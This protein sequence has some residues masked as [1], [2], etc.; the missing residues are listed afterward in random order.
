METPKSSKSEVYRK[1]REANTLNELAE[2]I[3]YEFNDERMAEICERMTYDLLGFLP[4][5]F[6]I[7][8]RAREI[9]YYNKL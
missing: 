6:R 9:L 3:R 1:V 2:I 8:M 5:D 4:R 7:R